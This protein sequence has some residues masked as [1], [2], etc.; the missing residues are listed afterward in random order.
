MFN[1]AFMCQRNLDPDDYFKKLIQP[2][3]LTLMDV[4]LIESDTNEGI[5]L[6]GIIQ[7]LVKWQEEQLNK[8]RALLNRPK[9]KSKFAMKL[10]KEDYLERVD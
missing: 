4:I 9:C 8:A 2:E 6:L 10:Q 1:I 7:T 3:L 5:F